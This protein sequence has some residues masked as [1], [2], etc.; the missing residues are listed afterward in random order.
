MAELLRQ[1]PH[2]DPEFAREAEAVAAQ[3]KILTGGRFTG[4]YRIASPFQSLPRVPAKTE[5][6]NA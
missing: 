5:K 6:T 3:L 2:L 1:N 4:Q